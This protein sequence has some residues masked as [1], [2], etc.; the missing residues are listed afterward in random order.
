MNPIFKNLKHQATFEKEGYLLI[1]PIL[2]T[3]HQLIRYFI[4]FLFPLPS[5]A[6]PKPFPFLPNILSSDFWKLFNE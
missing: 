5:L 1:D 3:S 2:S 4:P 6:P